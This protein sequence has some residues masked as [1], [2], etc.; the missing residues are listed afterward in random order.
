MKSEQLYWNG[1]LTLSLTPQRTIIQWDKDDI[2]SMPLLKVD[3]LALGIL[4]ALRRSVEL[5][6]TYDP[7]L[8]ALQDIP[9]EDSA[10]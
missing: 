1:Y 6:G 8:Q 2:E 4:S 10:T 9:R 3:I 7:T 5:I